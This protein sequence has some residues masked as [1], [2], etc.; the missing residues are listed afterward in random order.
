MALG[1]KE[2]AMASSIF[3]SFPPTSLHLHSSNK[4]LSSIKFAVANSPPSLKFSYRYTSK[5]PSFQ[6]QSA[7]ESLANVAEETTVEEEGKIEKSGN[8]NIRRKLFVLNLPWSFSVVD[9]KT[10]FSECGDVSDVEIIKQKDGKNRGFAFVTMAS[11]DGAQAAIEKF[12]SYEVVGRI[13]RVQFAKRFKK[14]VRPAPVIV[15]PP[16]ETRHRIYVSNL[17]WKVRSNNLRELFSSNFNPV[18]ARVIFDNPSGRSAGYG[19]VSFATKEEAESAINELDGKELLGRPIRLKFSERGSTASESKEES[20]S[21][22]AESEAESSAEQPE[23][24]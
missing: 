10:L 22:A 2:A 9:I 12:D 15:P 7:P 5:R 14:P 19:F 1:A 18:S 13:I 20:N 23:E 8:A 21:V 24:S 11:G 16:G 3:S 6:L 4:S 17:A